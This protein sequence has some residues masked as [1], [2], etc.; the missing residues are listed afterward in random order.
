MKF[1]NMLR[2]G[3]NGIGVTKSN[4]FEEIVVFLLALTRV[5]HKANF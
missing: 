4:V 2:E 5:F 3:V 1:D